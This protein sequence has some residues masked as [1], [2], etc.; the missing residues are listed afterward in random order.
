MCRMI[1]DNFLFFSLLFFHRC[2]VFIIS[3]IVTHTHTYTIYMDGII[4]LLLIHFTLGFSFFFLLP[5]ALLLDFF[6]ILSWE[7]W[8]GSSDPG[9]YCCYFWI[10]KRKKLTNRKN[11]MCACMSRRCENV[12][13]WMNEW[14]KLDKSNEN[15]IFTMAAMVKMGENQ[16]DKNC[17]IKYIGFAVKK[18]YSD[19]VEESVTFIEGKKKFQPNQLNFRDLFIFISFLLIMYLVLFRLTWGQLK[20]NNQIWPAKWHYCQIG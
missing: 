13:Y 7:K 10:K 6:S 18:K 9:N 19:W 15:E 8:W 2:Q 5:Y 11:P 17:W 20:K 12:V 4:I 1:N 3:L 16:R 14:M